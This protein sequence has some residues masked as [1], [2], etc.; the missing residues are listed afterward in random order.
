MFYNFLQMNLQK[1]YNV[2]HKQAIMFVYIEWFRCQICDIMAAQ[3]YSCISLFHIQ[4]GLYSTAY[5]SKQYMY[6]VDYYCF[7]VFIVFKKRRDFVWRCLLS[8]GVEVRVRAIEVLKHHVDISDID[9]YHIDMQVATFT[10]LLITSFTHVED[11]VR[12]KGHVLVVMFGSTCSNKLG[13]HW[14]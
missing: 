4:Q 5:C 13:K 1:K 11:Y 12:K 10:H 2:N 3:W 8:V 7:P 9:G 14:M 6:L